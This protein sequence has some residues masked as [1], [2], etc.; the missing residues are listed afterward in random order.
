MG[1]TKSIARNED[2]KSD[3]RH[4]VKRS[5]RGNA[6]TDLIFEA[7]RLN[8]RLLSAGDRLGADL[9]ITSA[10][11]QVLGSVKSEPLT[12]SQIARKMGLTRQAVQRVA[13]DLA[14]RDLVAFVDNPEHRKAKLVVLTAAGKK[15]TREMDRRQARWSDWL[16][17]VAEP[18]DIEYVARMLA[19]FR[20]KL[21]T[22]YTPENNSES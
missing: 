10:R 21:E 16:G 19:K 1:T 12:V 9:E 7:F 8:G 5:A 15:K 11:W 4:G 13:N 2:A 18:R 6:V 14:H 22:E 3:G 20:E 17:Q